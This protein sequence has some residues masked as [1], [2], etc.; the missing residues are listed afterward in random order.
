MD[1]IITSP[2]F[3]TLYTDIMREQGFREKHY[4]IVGKVTIEFSAIEYFLTYFVSELISPNA[5]LPATLALKKLNLANILEI[6][7]SIFQLQEANSET[8]A[9]FERIVSDINRL[10]IKR[11]DVI[12]SMWNYD[13][14]NQRVSYT[15]L[16]TS[17]QKRV[18]FR[19][20]AFSLE[21]L[22]NLSSEVSA[23]YHQLLDFIQAWLYGVQPRN[24]T[25]LPT[26][27]GTKP[28]TA[29]KERQKRES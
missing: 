1:T 13:Y 29:T 4:K 23:V 22:T 18:Q 2:G 28:P 20:E 26:T 24:G 12:H 7:P 19:N 15:R 11:N 10:R 5:A 17:K 21:D 25:Q 9:I 3:A 14:V 8:R 27:R 6:A 16:T